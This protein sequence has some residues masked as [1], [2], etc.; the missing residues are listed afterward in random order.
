MDPN[1]HPTTKRLEEIAATNPDDEISMMAVRYM[2]LRIWMG[3]QL[4]IGYNHPHDCI[5]VD[6]EQIRKI[7]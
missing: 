4:T 7:I 6:H 5:C 1:W 2:E 3:W